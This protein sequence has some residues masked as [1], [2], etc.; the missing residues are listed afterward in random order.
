M[1]MLNKVLKISL[2]AVLLLQQTVAVAA[3]TTSCEV[4]SEV[5]FFPLGDTRDAEVLTK[6]EIT[7]E[8]TETRTITGECLVWDEVHEFY[9]FNRTESE[10]I[11][12][13]YSGSM[14][15]MI[16]MIGAFGQIDHIFSGWK[17]HCSVGMETD[18]DWLNDPYMWAS[19]AMTMMGTSGM[20]DSVVSEIG[21]LGTCVL[22]SG[23]DIA[24]A[25]ET[26][27]GS[28]DVDANC[29]PV[30]EFC[31]DENNIDSKE[32]LTLD[33][34]Q[35]YDIISEHPELIDSI[36]VLTPELLSNTEP[37]DVI[38]IR[39]KG[40]QDIDTS[41]MD[42]QEVREAEEKVNETAGTVKAVV[43]AAQIAACA[44]TDQQ[45]GNSGSS[46]GTT[47]L[48]GDDGK[49]DAGGAAVMVLGMINP[50]LGMVAQLVMNLINSF[51]DIDTCNNEEDA[52]AKGKRHEKTYGAL[53]VGNLCH[54]TYSEC[55]Y[56]WGFDDCS[57]TGYWYCC[58]DQH[59]TKILTEQIK[60]Q[61]GKDWAHCSDISLREL[62]YVKFRQ[63]TDDDRAQGIDGGKIDSDKADQMI[64]S[65]GYENYYE[66]AMG[67][68]YQAKTQCIDLQE[69]FD[70]FE[71]RFGTEVDISTLDRTL[72]ALPGV[73]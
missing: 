26:Y 48:V 56:K 7:R 49:I 37:N 43:A 65:G 55:E 71:K 8:C 14:G 4:V 2:A 11:T 51:D 5:E 44:T 66:M 50:L 30:D 72:D 69:F 22:Q 54:A 16:S 23:A 58:Y 40:M 52:Q 57:R 70:E 19:M 38:A 41:G 64:N 27:S 29:D 45:S 35:Y 21:Q 31:D 17:G 12:E 25:V 47:S 15:S 67:E 18:F 20:M 59:I 63:C 39:V 46:G 68:Y 28:N 6:K 3:T 1:Q 9:D 24:G 33:E 36:E 32:V 13:D 10:Y 61:L 34:V 42:L 62:G 60:A 73:E 53:R